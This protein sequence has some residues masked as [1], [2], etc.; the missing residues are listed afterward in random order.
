MTKYI[1]V[2]AFSYLILVT[3]SVILGDVLSLSMLEG[4]N[5]AALVLAFIIAKECTSI[6]VGIT[7]SKSAVAAFT[8]L[9]YCLSS[10]Y[11]SYLQWESLLTLRENLVVLAISQLTIYVLMKVKAI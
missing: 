4:N 8:S 6:D 3:F 9:I 7:R 2:I 10:N 1:S 11:I 5:L